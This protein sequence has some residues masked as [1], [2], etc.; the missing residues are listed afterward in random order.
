MYTGCAQAGLF[1]RDSFLRDVTL[2]WLENLH[3]FSNLSDKF[4][5]NAMWHTW[6]LAAIFLYWMLAESDVTVAPSSTCM[7]LRK[8]PNFYRILQMGHS[9]GRYKN[10]RIFIEFCKWGTPGAVT[11]TVEFLQTGH[12]W[13]RYTNCRILTNGA[14][15][16]PLHKLSNFYRILQMG[17]PWGRYTNCRIFTNGAPLVSIHKL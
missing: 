8:L 4:P 14:P 11:Q 10:C 15:L 7:G 13:G 9:W 2:T 12:P 3:D 16:G 6:S 17:H 5:L 1:L